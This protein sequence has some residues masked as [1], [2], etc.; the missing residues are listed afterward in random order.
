M[1]EVKA[2]LVGNLWK[3][4]TEVGQVVEEDETLMI[5]ESMKM[6]IPITSPVS[7]TVRQ[8][9]VAEGEVVQDGQTVAVVD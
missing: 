8:I 5:L 3:I 2:E 9:L 1:A 4:V 7:G 6:E